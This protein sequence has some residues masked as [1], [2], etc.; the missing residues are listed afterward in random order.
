MLLGYA[1]VSTES[2]HLDPQITALTESGVEA[3]RIY[4]DKATGANAVRPGL[5][6]V[7]KSLREGDTLVVVKLD[8]L[9]RSLKDLIRLGEVIE[10][11]GA[12]L[13]VL[14]AGIDTGT[15]VGRLT[16]HII[17]ALA[18]FELALIRE[19]TQ[20]GLRAAREKGRR[21]GRKKAL[22]GKTL[23]LARVLWANPAFAVADIAAQIKVSRRTLFRELGA[24]PVPSSDQS[25]QSDQ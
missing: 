4:T 18:E 16:F 6:A 13:R 14:D 9:A 25:D 23:D 8:R 19:R 11:K 3:D 17:G 21:G 22:E 2:Q 10:G 1:R 5:E 20:T 12:A 7:L 15:P 24:R